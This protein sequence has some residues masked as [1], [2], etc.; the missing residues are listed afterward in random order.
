MA[1]ATKKPAAKKQ[2]LRRSGDGVIAA[3]IAGEKIENE[4]DVIVSTNGEWY[5]DGRALLYR[6]THV[7]NRMW[8]VG[9]RMKSGGILATRAHFAG[10]HKLRKQVS[11]YTG[12]KFL[13]HLWCDVDAPPSEFVEALFHQIERTE[14]YTGSP[15]TRIEVVL[16]WNWLCHEIGYGQHV[17]LPPTT[18]Y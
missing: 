9:L 14:R 5:Y 3:F 16:F 12:T 10:L 2:K 4:G 15:K 13:V 6:A 8:I 7:P 1:T 18:G 11:A 17:T